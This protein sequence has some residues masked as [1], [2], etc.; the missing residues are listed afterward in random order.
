M[1]GAYKALYKSQTEQAVLSTVG[2]STVEACLLWSSSK[3]ADH[4]AHVNVFFARS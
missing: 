3:P 2:L 4:Q 1:Q